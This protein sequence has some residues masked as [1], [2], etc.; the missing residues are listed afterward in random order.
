MRAPNTRVNA[1]RTVRSPRPSSS[2]PMESA[3]TIIM[4]RIVKL[5]RRGEGRS[6]FT[7]ASNAAREKKLAASSPKKNM[8]S[9]ANNR[10]R[11]PKNC[12]MCCCRP[13]MPST[14]APIRMKLI[15]AIQKIKRLSSSLD[16]GSAAL[17][18]SCEAP[19]CSDSL[20]NRASRRIVRRIDLRT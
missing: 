15:Q 12:E 2:K 9:A 10:G 8:N 3:K 14:L 11:N 7:A 6:A 4:V 1:T 19:A 18:R 16:G 20:S 13:P 17:R 5:T